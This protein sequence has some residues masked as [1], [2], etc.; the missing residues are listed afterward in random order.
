MVMLN[1]CLPQ[2]ERFMNRKLD[3]AE[4]VLRNRQRKARRW[5]NVFTTGEE[6]FQLHE[7]HIFIASFVAGVAVGVVTG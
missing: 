7:V 2:V 5:Y 1:H 4:D 6:G 3:K